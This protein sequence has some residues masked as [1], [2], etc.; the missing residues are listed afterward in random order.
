MSMSTYKTSTLDIDLPISNEWIVNG[1]NMWS[2]IVIGFVNNSDWQSCFQVSGTGRGI[3]RWGQGSHFE[4][5]GN[6]S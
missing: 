3:P 4:K 1:P 6:G 5:Q 2:G